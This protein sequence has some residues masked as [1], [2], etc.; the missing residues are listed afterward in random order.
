MAISD[1]PAVSSRTRTTPSWSALPRAPAAAMGSIGLPAPQAAAKNVGRP[2]RQAAIDGQ[3][4]T[5]P[6]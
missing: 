4:T 1:A 6:G 5:D 3:A 2:R